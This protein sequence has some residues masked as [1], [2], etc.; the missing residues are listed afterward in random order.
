M[1]HK[2]TV[3]RYVAIIVIAIKYIGYVCSSR[4]VSYYGKDLIESRD[5]ALC[6]HH[7]AAAAVMVVV[8]VMG[9]APANRFH[10]QSLVSQWGRRQCLVLSC[11]VTSID[12]LNA[13][14]GLIEWHA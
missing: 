12:R 6:T 5:K 10:I 2:I 9:V 4:P 11:L 7:L 14:F 3:S 8:V 13:L 1:R